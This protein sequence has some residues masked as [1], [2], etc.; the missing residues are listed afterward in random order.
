MIIQ[1]SFSKRIENQVEISQVFVKNHKKKDV[2]ENPPVIQTH[3][4]ITSN[5]APDSKNG[6]ESDMPKIRKN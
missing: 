5:P 2:D 6:M 1:Y 3:T 4:P